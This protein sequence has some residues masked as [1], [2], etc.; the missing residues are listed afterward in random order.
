MKIAKR[1]SPPHFLVEGG[2]LPALQA[3][4]KRGKAVA[5]EKKRQETQVQAWEGEG[6]NLPSSIAGVEKA[7]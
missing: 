1:C 5:V 2:K 3:T 4:P 7:S 6:G